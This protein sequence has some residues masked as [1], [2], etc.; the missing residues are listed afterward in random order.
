MLFIDSYSLHC[1]KVFRQCRILNIQHHMQNKSFRKRG[2]KIAGIS[3][4]IN[5][6][7][8]KQK[9]KKPN[10]VGIHWRTHSSA[11]LVKRYK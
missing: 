2:N 7:S 4:N 3:W 11:E 5:L 8:S 6:E 9:S 1:T 10:K